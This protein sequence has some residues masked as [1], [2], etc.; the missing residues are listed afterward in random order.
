[1]PPLQP[2]Y[3]RALDETQ[4]VPEF[5]EALGDVAV[6]AVVDQHIE[7]LNSLSP[8]RPWLPEPHCARVTPDLWELRCPVRTDHGAIDVGILYAVHQIYAILLHASKGTG[9]N[10]PADACPIA[11]ERWDDF[12]ARTQGHELSPFGS[13]AP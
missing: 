9:R 12:R 2:V 13:W 6:W 7:R 3:Y 5:T 11:E 4:P 8:D 1:M 10:R